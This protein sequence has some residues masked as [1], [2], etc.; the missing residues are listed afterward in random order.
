M[1]L[2]LAI[3][4]L[5]ASASALRGSPM[6]DSITFGDAVSEKAHNFSAEHAEVI[7]GASGQTARRLLPLESR[8]WE[9]GRI[10]FTLRV[11][12]EKQNYAT[13]R[14]SGSDVT[15]NDLVLFCDGKQIGY[16]H[17]GDIDLLDI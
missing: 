13:I 6:A 11:D 7:S 10:S 8:S 1:K 3:L 4:F 17:L 16:R 2:N 14:L 9:G 15:A 12:P 5:C